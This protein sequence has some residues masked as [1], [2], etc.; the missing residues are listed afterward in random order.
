MLVLS[1]GLSGG[2][3]TP[4]QFTV[5]L[6]T[7]VQFRGKLFSEEAYTLVI[8]ENQQAFQN[9]LDFTIKTVASPRVGLFS[10]AFVCFAHFTMSGNLNTRLLVVCKFGILQHS[11]VLRRHMSLKQYLFVSRTS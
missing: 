8:G 11:I 2:T 7:P 4:D 6:P 5:P 9:W 1:C 10:R 3:P